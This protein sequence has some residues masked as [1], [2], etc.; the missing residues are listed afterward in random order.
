MTDTGYVVLGLIIMFVF[1]VLP[2]FCCY[3]TNKK[4]RS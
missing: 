1:I 2:F 4:T 3:N